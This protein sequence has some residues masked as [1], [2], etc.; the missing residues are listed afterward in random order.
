MFA[1]IKIGNQQFKVAE[2]QVFLA[3]K[4]GKEVGSEFE[5]E[6][7]LLAGDNKVSIG[8]PEVGEAKVK[9]QVLEDVKGKKIH[10]FKY[11]RR[12]NYHRSWG[13]RQQ[14]QKLK[15]THISL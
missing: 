15:V 7:L 10:G 9:L 8:S 2:N 1:I 6:A 14:L 5:A 12:K 13:H 11:K 4:T 3:Q